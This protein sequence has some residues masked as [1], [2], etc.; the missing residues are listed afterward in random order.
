VCILSTALP[1]HVISPKADDLL[2]PEF[3]RFMFSRNTRDVN[4]S[5]SVLSFSFPTHKGYVLVGRETHRVYSSPVHNCALWRWYACRLLQRVLC[6]LSIHSFP[7]ISDPRG[8]VAKCSHACINIGALHK[9][10]YYS[11]HTRRLQHLI[12]TNLHTGQYY[13]SD[14]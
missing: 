3:A 4:H 5:E 1:P 6:L 11:Q 14:R 12:V 7:I 13:T 2:S 9:V 10:S 8:R